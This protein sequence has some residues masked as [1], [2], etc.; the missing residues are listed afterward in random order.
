MTKRAKTSFV[1]ASNPPR[2][3]H[4]GAL[5]EDSDPVLKGRDDLFEN[6]EEYIERMKAPEQATAAPGE[7]RSLSSA[8]KRAVKKDEPE[9]TS[10]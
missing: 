9:G 6:V 4:A 7:R 10:K 5:F 1:T 3:V 8:R 2:V